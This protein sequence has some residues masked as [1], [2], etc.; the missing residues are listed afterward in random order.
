MLEKKGAFSYEDTIDK[1]SEK[2]EKVMTKDAIEDLVEH[3]VVDHTNY[4]EVAEKVA[5]EIVKRNG[6][7]TGEGLEEVLSEIGINRYDLPKEFIKQ[8]LPE[9]SF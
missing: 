6:N 3:I 4:Y 8:Y 5:G 2:M 7:L 9:V 1:V